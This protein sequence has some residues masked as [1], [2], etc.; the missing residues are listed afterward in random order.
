MQTIIFIRIEQTLNG[1]EKTTVK[2][3]CQIKI[4]CLKNRKDIG[5]KHKKRILKLKKKY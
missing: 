4:L 1:N 3:L 2:I 5:P